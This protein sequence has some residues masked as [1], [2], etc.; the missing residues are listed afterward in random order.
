MPRRVR[1]LVEEAVNHVNAAP[2]GASRCSRTV[3]RRFLDVVR[4]VKR[5]DRFAVVAWCV[6]PNHCHLGSVPGT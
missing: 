3:E 4:V 2:R 5:R 6:M 1:V